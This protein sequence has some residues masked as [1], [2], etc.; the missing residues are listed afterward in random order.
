MANVHNGEIP[1]DL[2]HAIRKNLLKP[3]GR[4][5]HLKYTLGTLGNVETE[6]KR[7]FGTDTSVFEIMERNARNPLKISVAET[8]ILL[9][10]GLRDQF[11]SMTRDLAASILAEEDFM[12]VTATIAEG[13]NLAFHGTKAF[14]LEEAEEE[15]PEDEFITNAAGE[16]GA[17]ADDPKNEE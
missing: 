11:P 17:E 2:S 15:K 12:E 16:E 4:H 8:I 1:I 5:V 14:Q 6:F 9:Q 3:R 10:Y 13:I 7:D